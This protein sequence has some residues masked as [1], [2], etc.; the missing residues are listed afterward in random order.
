RRFVDGFAPI[1]FKGFAEMH[2]LELDLGENYR[3]GPLRLILSGFIEYFTPTSAFAAQQA[4]VEAVVPYIEA[5]DHNGR[6]TK[7]VEEMGFPAGLH[8]TMITDLSGRLPEGTRRIRITTNLM[9]YWDQVLIDTTADSPET[10][11][12]DVPLARAEL[13]RLGF[14]RM[15]EGHP[16]SDVRFDYSEVSQTGPYARHAGNFTRYGD[17]RALVAVAEDKF[18]VLASGDEVAL[19]FDPAELPPLPPGWM[20]DYFFYAD[21]F[22]KDMDFHAAQAFTVDPLPFHGMESYPYPSSKTYPQNLQSLEYLL[23]YNTRQDRGGIPPTLRFEY[24]RR[25]PPLP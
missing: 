12:N 23:N 6:W 25:N 3:A 18:A 20:R 1:A 11:L 9:I 19:D 22:T 2:S 7:V 8:R 15:V 13:R 21:A 16:K 4:G 5:Q 17:V 10:R 14:P 24:Q